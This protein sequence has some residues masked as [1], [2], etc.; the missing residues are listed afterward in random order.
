MVMKIL[1]AGVGL[2]VATLLLMLLFSV[3]VHVR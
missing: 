1:F 3:I 2:F